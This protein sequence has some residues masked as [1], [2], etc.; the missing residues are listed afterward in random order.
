MTI[1]T[2]TIHGVPNR[3]VHMPKAGEK[4]VSPIGI[5]SR[6]AH[7]VVSAHQQVIAGG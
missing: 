1:S 7:G 5:P 2:M 3:S 4:K 6:V